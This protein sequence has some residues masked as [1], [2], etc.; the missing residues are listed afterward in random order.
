MEALAAEIGKQGEVVKEIKASNAAK[1]KIDEEVAKLVTLKKKMTELDP[2]HPMA[3][4]DKAAK[5]KKEKEL[6][7]SKKAAS[8]EA[9]GDEISKNEAKKLAKKMAKKEKKEQHK[10]V[11]ADDAPVSQLSEAVYYAVDS[12]P[13][14]ARAATAL[15]GDSIAFCKV[16]G[17]VKTQPYYEFPSGKLF[18]DLAIAR[19][20][21]RRN[22]NTDM[23]GLDA[24]ESSFVDQWTDFAL[25][26]PA[27][28]DT[29]TFAGVLNERLAQGTYIVGNRLTLADLACW[30]VLRDWSHEGFEHV[31]R[32]LKLCEA[33]PAMKEALVAR[34]HKATKPASPPQ[35][36]ETANGNEPQYVA[37]AGIA[38]PVGA[39]P[40][41]DGAQQGNV[42]TRF[43]PEPSGYLHVGQFVR[44][45]ITMSMSI[46]I[47]YL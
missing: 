32:W 20:I 4:V 29:A 19:F 25:A 30:A 16:P 44:A 26:Y 22:L 2:S 6:K 41:L 33:Q 46:V 10:R 23:L 35:H 31:G 5:K 28:G 9:A 47:A 40:P 11:S 43:P 1:E 36:V 34:E 14:V 3:H 24:L 18:G 17:E 38:V 39:C 42:V 13:L 27:V 45:A 7:N 12:Q 37:N 15:V 8:P 21:L